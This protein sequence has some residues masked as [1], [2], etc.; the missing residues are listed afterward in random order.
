MNNHLDLA[1]IIGYLVFIVSLGL[2]VAIRSRKR[3]KDSARNYFL[4][5][6]T[7]KWPVIGL[8]LFSTNIS[9]IH[10]VALAQQGFDNGLAFGNFE[11]MAAFTLIILSLFFV[12]FY[13]RAKVTTLPEF[14]EKRY[15]D[16][17]IAGKQLPVYKFDHGV[18]QDG[19]VEVNS[20][21]VTIGKN[22][23]SLKLSTVTKK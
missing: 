10:L 17:M 6:G 15:D 5:S 22:K 4:A 16:D 8:A 14:L 12:P 2:W 13:I 21:Q 19:D 11:W 7:L 1:I 9:T 23:V 20:Q 18:L 3:S